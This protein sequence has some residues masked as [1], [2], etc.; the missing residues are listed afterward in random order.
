MLHSH[1][2][3]ESKNTREA[4]KANGVRQLVCWHERDKH[5]IVAGNEVKWTWLG[6]LCWKLH[7]GAINEGRVGLIRIEIGHVE[8]ACGMSAMGYTGDVQPGKKMASG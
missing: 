1:G 5:S 7:G 2:L 4:L 6:G 8:Q 3:V